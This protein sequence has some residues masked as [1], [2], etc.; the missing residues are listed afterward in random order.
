MEN[1]N[2]SRETI[3]EENEL[4]AEL[5]KSYDSAA[6]PE[7]ELIENV[8]RETKEV[9]LEESWSIEKFIGEKIVSIAGIGILVL[10]IFFIV[11][12]AIE[13][14]LLSDPAKIML[15]IVCGTLLSS[16]AHKLSKKYRAFSS[17][18]AWG[19]LA[20]FYFSI[21]QAFQSYHLLSQTIAFACIILITAFSVIMSLYYDKKELAILVILGGF[22]TPFLVIPIR[23]I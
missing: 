17:I 9:Q 12:W 1:E 18:L 5:G 6:I 8:S 20:V 4:L 19:G 10:G 3:S 13:R 2:V 14:N 11:K 23:Q 7:N 21:Y 16:I 22:F 15:G